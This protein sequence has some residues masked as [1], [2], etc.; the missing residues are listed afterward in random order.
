MP[1]ISKNTVQAGDQITRDEIYWNEGPFDNTMGDARAVSYAFRAST[2][3][4]YE[5][6]DPSNKH[7]EK[8]T[9]SRVSADQKA[10]IFEALGLWSDVARIRFDAVNPNGY[11][12][13]ATILF[14]NY[15]SGKDPNGKSVDGSSAFAVPPGG[16]L[17]P[18]R[19]WDERNGDVWFNLDGGSTTKPTLDSYSFETIVHELGHAIG[20][21]HPGNYN[22]GPGASF[23][24]EKNAAYIEDNTQYSIMSYF[25]RG[26]NADSP[27]LHDIAA[28]QRLYGINW[29][30]RNTDTVYG[31]N[32]TAGRTV[33]D[34]NANK[35]P[36]LA[37]WD[38][39]GRDTINLSG[40]TQSQRLDLNQEAFSDITPNKSAKLTNNLAIA[41]LV[42]IEKAVGG[43][44]G[45]SITGNFLGNDI[46]GGEG[47]DSIFGR[48]GNDW[49]MGELNN[50]N[51][52]GEN[53]NDILF[54]G[55]GNDELYG[56]EGN[57][58]LRGG[59]GDDKLFGWNGDDQMTAS[60]GNDTAFGDSGNDSIA[61]NEGN[62]AIFGGEGDD[63]LDGQEGNDVI[64]GDQG[65]NIIFGRAGDDRFES[66]AGGAN[67]VDGG[68][69]N[70]WYV[71]GEGADAITDGNGYDTLQFTSWV[72]ADWQNGSWQGE[73]I[74]ND[75]WQPTDFDQFVMSD[76]DDTIIMKSTFGQRFDLRGNGG[77]DTLQGG[78]GTDQ[79]WGD[80][81]NDILRG[82]GNN[83]QLF[84][85]TGAD[86]IA[87]NYGND[88]IDGGAGRDTAWFDDHYGNSSRGW[89]I[90]LG[91]GKATTQSE[92]SNQ[93]FGFFL[94]T[95]TDTL[96]SIENAVGSRGSDTII[97]GVGNNTIDGSAGYDTVSFADHTGSFKNGWDIDMIKGEGTT[98]NS[99]SG[100]F[101]FSKE[102]DTFKNIE[103]VI[104]SNG[105]DTIQANQGTVTEAALKP[106]F[107]PFV[108]GG[109][110]QDTL[111]LA[112]TI[113]S[114]T[115][116]F[117]QPD[118]NDQVAFGKAGEGTV[119]TS[120]SILKKAGFFEVFADA[121]GQLDFRN[122]ETLDTGAGN[123]KVTGSTGVERILLGS[124]DD[125][126]LLGGGDDWV[127]GGIGQDTLTGGA[128]KDRFR[129][130]TANDGSDSI[131]DFAAGDK[132]ELV[133]S[134][135]SNLAKGSLKAANFSANATG[136]ALQ[137]DDFIVYNTTNHTLWYDPDAN[138]DQQAY[139]IATLSNSY[140]LR[141]GDIE[142]V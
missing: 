41:R 96:K 17:D 45:D 87:G 105:H 139:S 66:R 71:L 60:D 24:Y 55:D 8:A 102:T 31:F 18:G 59:S 138:G 126:A 47:N 11:S 15:N 39:G 98:L 3:N 20:L 34:F 129:Y 49:L 99:R 13:G 43:S 79:V 51:L 54:G 22:A 115:S 28:V 44:G 1:S 120:T 89:T 83:D 7:N 73:L 32:S 56:D 50:D 23:T 48:D 72:Y 26:P 107:V 35:T 38:G 30:T 81:G 128:G 101:L 21:Q 82:G 93:R 40:Y 67:T 121:N 127:T 36:H 52:H 95:E 111:K 2:P 70:D 33:Y 133:S 77:A 16:S 61:G 141:A 116:I 92:I 109:A 58:D 14:G 69:G 106:L 85:G 42:D 37:I 78:N 130:E 75:F 123:D 132:L 84:G 68:A 114:A 103:N 97:G 112:A 6:S 110:G 10:L 134:A 125:T 91:Q 74:T 131:T 62:D 29:D 137:S 27:L 140:L 63:L 80:S 142:I 88:V 136:T 12:N 53:G 100:V 25:D 135:F 65:N 4:D 9:F 104:G 117:F 90:D 19:D 94:R 5:Y 119:L 76:A 108:D 46:R 64:I 57:D 118:A 124:G 86:N 122:I 113:Q